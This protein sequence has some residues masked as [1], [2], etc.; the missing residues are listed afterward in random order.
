MFESA[1]RYE[2]ILQAWCIWLQWQDER[3]APYLV[4]WIA[5]ITG[6]AC[7]WS[8][9]PLFI[10]VQLYGMESKKRSFIANGSR[11]MNEDCL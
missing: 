1:N 8:L 5:A 9:P 2:E 11:T 4:G 3:R 10:A 7:K 6:T